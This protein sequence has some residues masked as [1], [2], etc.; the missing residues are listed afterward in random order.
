LL[1]RRLIER[2]VRFVTVNMYE[3]VFD[4]IT[5]DIHGSK[6]FTDIAEMS[7]LVAP[8]F[9]RAYSALLEDLH[10]RGLL[11]TTIV[12]AMG[13]FGRTPKI[14]GNTGRDH[15]PGAWSTV[16]CGGGIKGGQPYGKT[17]ADGNKVETK[18]TSVGDFLATVCSALGI[19]PLKQNNSNVGRP[20]RIA[21]P[22]AK[23]IKEIVA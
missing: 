4:E 1:A 7:R 9:D 8:D 18:P 10:D 2:G 19:D 15:F 13:E 11:K 22:T 17:S 6:P 20:I 5:W 23:P 16:L 3:T 14:N 21:E 12:T